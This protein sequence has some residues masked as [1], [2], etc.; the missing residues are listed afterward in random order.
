MCYNSSFLIQEIIER[1]DKLVDADA[2]PLHADGAV[3]GRGGPLAVVR[4]S[5]VLVGPGLVGARPPVRHG[6]VQLQGKV[7]RVH[8]VDV[9]VGGLVHIHVE[10]QPQLQQEQDQKTDIPKGW[11]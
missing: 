8:V 6:R 9:H 3:L 4:R 2:V 11:F 1:L 7:I 5:Q 10:V